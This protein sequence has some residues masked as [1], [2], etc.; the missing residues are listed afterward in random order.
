MTEKI[1]TYASIGL[2]VTLMML[3]LNK[4]SKSRP[5]L[6][7]EGNVILKLSILYGI[8]GLISFISGIAIIIYGLIYFNSEEFLFRLIFFGI[9]GVSGCILILQQWGSKVILTEQ[10]IIKISMFG[11]ISRIKWKEIN[12][13]KFN[14]ASWQLKIQSEK[15]RINCHMHLVG[16]PK[17]VERLEKETSISRYQMKIPPV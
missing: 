5:E 2:I 4:A 9:F 7:S 13:V 15:T 8:T 17:L 16:F 11:K 10:E 6:N 3:Y 12:D 1:S 14:K